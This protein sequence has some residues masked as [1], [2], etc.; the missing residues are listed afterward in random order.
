MDNTLYVGL[1]K[2]V[3]L[4]R[5][6]DIVANNLANVDTTG[7]KVEQLLNAVD[8][9]APARS[10]G[11]TPPINFVSDNG[12]ARDYTQG[13]L[14]QTGSPLDLAI[15]TQGFFQISTASGNVYTRD[16]RFATN[17]Q[18]QLVTQSGDPVLDASGS[19]ITLNSQGGQP[20]IAG[21]GSISQMVP[22]QSQAQTIGRV[23]VVS[24]S[25]LSSLSKQGDG[26]FT[27]TTNAQATP[28]TGDVIRQGMLETS[29]VQPIV[30]VTD[31][32]RISRTYDMIS[33]ILNE[34]S[35]LSQTA[36]QRLGSV[37]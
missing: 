37:Q 24:F 3:L 14:R 25:D 30:E 15:T 23:G 20:Q 6:L 12:V 18:N 17:S 21:D 5:E 11:V 31:L 9:T 8:P 2:Q 1:S 27:N 33:N 22:G 19:P 13:A 29:N 16:G 34:T 35:S 7:F 10:T 28:V 4:Q 36:I 32:I 26:Y